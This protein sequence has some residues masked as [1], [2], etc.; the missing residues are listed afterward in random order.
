VYTGKT[1]R[2][3]WFASL[4]ALLLAAAP[5]LGV[6]C[7]MDCDEPPAAPACHDSMATPDGSIVRAAQHTCDHDHATVDPALLSQT[8]AREWIGTVVA[9]SIPALT[10]GFLPG[11]RLAVA[12]MQ[13][14]PGAIAPDTS[15]SITVLRI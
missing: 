14:P 3:R 6:V 10:H 9:V 8:G 13:G 1:V 11:A 4:L 15:S 7:Q 5:L 2:I 12:S